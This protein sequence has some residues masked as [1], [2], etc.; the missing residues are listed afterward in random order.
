MDS[1]PYTAPLFPNDVLSQHYRLSV[2]LPEKSSFVLGEMAGLVGLSFGFIAIIIASFLV[3]VRSIVRQQR[4]SS[5]VVAFIN[6]MTHEF[7]TPISTIALA[8]EAIL[9]PEILKSRP[10][11]RTY[12][13]LI[14]EENARM[15]QQ[16]DTILQM[17]VLERGEFEVKMET[18]DIHTIIANA[19]RNVALI[20]EQRNG[21][22]R[23][24]LHA[25]EARVRGD[26]HHLSNVIRNLLDNAIKYSPARPEIDIATET[27]P[28]GVHIRISDRGIGIASAEID[29][30]FE[31]YFRVS[32]GN[33]HDV[34]G[35]GLGLSYVKLIVEA[36]HGTI[37][38]R[39][40]VGKGTVVEVM[41][42]T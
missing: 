13:S 4:F 1:P 41:L 7:K 9:K 15:K 22:I 26:Q 10:K 12:T 32:R 6:N 25:K 27:G 17:A 38:L 39:S 18:V 3:T 14:A 8:A 40:E 24:E 37:S 28:D 23:T 34:K 35:F 5:S 21:A 19:V 20:V 33:T 36:H 29:R 30:V 31:P 42:P 2:Y 16:V 11:L